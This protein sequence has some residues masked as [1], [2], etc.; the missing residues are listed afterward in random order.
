MPA[1]CEHGA[2]PQFDDGDA[3]AAERGGGVARWR[4]RRALAAASAAA[5]LLLAACCAVAY[6]RPNP[7][8]RAEVAAQPAPVQLLEANGNGTGNGTG[9]WMMRSI[10]S[11]CTNWASAMLQEMTVE[12]DPHACG[13]RCAQTEGCV[14]FGYQHGGSPE[15]HLGRKQSG[16]CALWKTPCVDMENPYWDDYEMTE[17]ATSFPSTTS[18]I[19]TEED[20]LATQ[21]SMG[22]IRMDNLDL[23]K[24]RGSHE[25]YK[26]FVLTLKR[27]L[28][29]K[30]GVRPR[31]VQLDFKD[32]ERQLEVKE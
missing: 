19:M 7:S 11:G 5:F 26:H 17:L 15:W 10:G 6:R 20:K 29:A 16:G 18:A 32:Q 25:V 30:M 23:R 2:L 21:V 4:N 8:S 22:S 9:K 28:A 31:D 3:T 14:G 13:R 24:L 12:P 1:P 27:E